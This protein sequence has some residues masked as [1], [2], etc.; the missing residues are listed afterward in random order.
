MHDSSRV[1]INL[2]RD[3]NEDAAAAVF[4]RY[5]SRLIGLTRNR[6]SAKLARRV[7][8]EDVVQSAF[9]SFFRRAEAGEY[10]LSES[11][12]LWRLLAVITLNK[13]RRKAEYHSAAKRNY[14]TERQVENKD[15]STPAFEAVSDGPSPEAQLEISEEIE[16]MTK[17]F[18][19]EH[20]RVIELRLQGYKLEEIATD[21][22]CSERTVRR[23]LDRFREQLESRLVDLESA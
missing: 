2:L 10:E 14:S 22:D 17:G 6:L 4:D 1:L 21:I 9:R 7:D 5:V 19:H 8:P 20:Q 16:V 3:G 12:N 18:S 15:D 13:L 23:V 11:G